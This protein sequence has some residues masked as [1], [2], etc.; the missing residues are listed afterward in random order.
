MGK[1]K[2]YLIFVREL[3][4]LEE[5]MKTRKLFLVLVL[6]VILLMGTGLVANAADKIRV[7]GGVNNT[8]FGIG[9]EWIRVNLT[10]DPVTHEAIGETN[11][12]GSS[13]L[14]V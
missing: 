2:Y 7:N 11:Y 8:L 13:C 1:C 5:K 9:W 14:R 3:C 10:I 6:V 12:M 4:F